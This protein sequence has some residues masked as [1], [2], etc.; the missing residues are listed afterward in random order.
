MLP[1]RSRGQEMRSIQAIPIPTDEAQNF[2][3]SSVNNNGN[4]DEAE[5]ANPCRDAAET[6]GGRDHYPVRPARC[7]LRAD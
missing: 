4:A 2:T 5:D 7:D 3:S 1:H 6:L